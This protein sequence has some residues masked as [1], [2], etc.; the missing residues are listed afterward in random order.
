MN[1]FADTIERIIGPSLEEMGFGIV[2][3]SFGGG[4]RKRL[5]IMI[6]RLDDQN[7]SLDDCADVS[8]T[9]SALLDVE[10]PISENYVLEVSSPGIDRPLVKLKDYV[11]FQGSDIQLEL[12]TLYEGRKRF[13]GRLASVDGEEITLELPE[14]GKPIVKFPYSDVQKA[15]VIPEISFK[16]TER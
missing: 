5:Q 16:K 1:S 12:N 4:N 15:K 8:R 11:R 6:E 2:R 14:D 13:S 3:I 7:L 10:D 9:V